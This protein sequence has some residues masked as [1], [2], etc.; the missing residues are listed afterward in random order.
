MTTLP[1]GVSQSDFDAAMVAMRAAV[2]EDW[3]FTSA[4]DVG[5]YRD[6][7][8]PLWDEAEERLPSAAVAPTAVEEVQAVMRIAN[9]FGIP[10][11]SI[12]TGKNLGYGGSAPNMTGSVVLDLKRMNRIIEV[13]DRRH[14]AIVEPGVSYFDLYRHIQ[15]VGLKV[16]LDVPGPGWGSPVGNSL[17]HGVGDTWGIYRNHFSAH[18][19]MEVVLADGTLIRTGMGALPGAE[20]WGEYPYGFGP[21]VDGLFAQGNF[22]VVTKMGFW[23]MP[24]PEAYMT[25]TITVPDR[26]D[27]SALIDLVNYLEHQGIGGEPLYGSPIR[28]D[29]GHADFQRLTAGGRFPTDAELDDFARSRGKPFWSV[30]LQYYGPQEI[31]QAQWEATK[32][33]ARARLRGA[34]FTDER[35]LSLPLGEEDR[36]TV[37]PVAFGIPSL[38]TFAL[39]ARSER[40]P[41][42]SDG[43]LF[44]SPVIPKSGEALLKFQRA[45]WNALGEMGMPRQIGPFTVPNTWMF[46]SFA[47]IV[48]FLISRSDP[49]ENAKVRE[50]FRHLIRVAAENG[51]GE[52]RTAPIFQDDV[53][54]TYSFNDNA[55]LKFHETLKDA[56]DPKGIL[57][58]GRGGIWP[59][60]L[61]KK[62]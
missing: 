2:G 57:A 42:G 55:L 1:S 37:D 18:C 14:F 56:A 25:G 62:S 26:G 45:M 54:A 33:L 20:T 30:K 48:V 32:R 7:F 36:A 52:Y 9:R 15:D 17:D 44:F 28:A 40:N 53:R 19:G 8:S 6:A 11:Y 5:L 29:A 47:V 61:R 49:A 31:V 39:T 22:G 4:E 35:F 59:R 51:W 24:E 27:I 46:H 16:W 43:H 23:L 34:G 12:S 60:H 3:V 50:T 41:D 38:A 58:A 10:I 21:M 13:D